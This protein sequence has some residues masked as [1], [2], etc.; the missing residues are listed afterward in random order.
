MKDSLENGES[1]RAAF[2]FDPVNDQL[3]VWKDEF[4]DLSAHLEMT[5][6]ISG[7]HY[8]YFDFVIQTY[9]NGDYDTGIIACDQEVIEDLSLNDY[10]K[11]ENPD[12]FPS[13][14]IFELSNYIK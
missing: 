3:E 7:N 9:D 8:Q 14:S 6:C 12:S 2:I 1:I 13:D 5:I 10:M 11:S 4:L